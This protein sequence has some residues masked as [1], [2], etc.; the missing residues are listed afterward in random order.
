[1]MV[2]IPKKLWHVWIGP[3]AAPTEWM[4][5][6]PDHHPD[7]EYCV[8]DNAMLASY[9]FKTRPLIEEFYRRGIYSGVAN[10]IRYELLY[11]HGGFALEADSICLANTDELWTEDE[12][13]FYAAYENEEKRPGYVSVQMAANPGNA[14]LKT[15]I[16][17]LCKHDISKFG[18][19]IS[20]FRTTGPKFLGDLVLREKP[21]A[22]IFPSHYFIPKHFTSEKR[23][24]GPDKVYADQL[25]GSTLQLYAKP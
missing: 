1:M 11:N 6:W 18:K 10:M 25:W 17:E 16:D 15:V 3:H 8:F 9:E 20:S 12:S 23:Y 24:N 13:C 7:W 2:N 4:K 21:H 22:R 5:T 14:F 19:N